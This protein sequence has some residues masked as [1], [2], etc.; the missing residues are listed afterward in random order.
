MGA[1]EVFN[2]NVWGDL[3][4]RVSPWQKS[5]QPPNPHDKNRSTPLKSKKMKIL[6]HPVIQL[7]E[8]LNH[9]CEFGQ[10]DVSVISH[11]MRDKNR[12]TL[13]ISRDKI[14]VTKIGAPLEF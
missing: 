2:N 6:K 12:M 7:Y 5:E 10:F 13:P 8:F 9:F 11:F 3:K 1:K 4:S 14:G